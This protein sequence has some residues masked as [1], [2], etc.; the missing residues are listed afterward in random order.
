MKQTD[1]SAFFVK[2]TW[3]L[4]YCNYKIDGFDFGDEKLFI[5]EMHQQSEYKGDQF[6]ITLAKTMSKF[7]PRI[8]AES[9]VEM[10]YFKEIFLNILNYCKLMIPEIIEIDLNCDYFVD[11]LHSRYRKEGVAELVRQFV[12]NGKPQFT[13][14]PII[15]R[16]ITAFLSSESPI[17]YNALSFRMFSRRKK[18]FDSQTFYKE[19]YEHYFDSQTFYKE[20][21]EHCINSLI[22]NERRRT[23]IE[24]KRKTEIELIRDHLEYEQR[25]LSEPQIFYTEI[26]DEYEIPII[27]TIKEV[28]SDYPGWVK[29]THLNEDVKNPLIFN[30]EIL[31][32]FYREFDGYFCKTTEPAIFK[33]W[34]RVEP[35]G[36]PDIEKDILPYFCYAVWGINDYR[37]KTRCPIIQTWFSALTGKKTLFSK[38]KGK[39]ERRTI[40]SDMQTDIDNRIKIITRPVNG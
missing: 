22:K 32:K 11:M 19:Y 26:L 28:A 4:Y 6:Y 37:D 5:E 8:P 36:Q 3:H 16:G 10:P 33:N 21:Y 38:F 20:Y 1:I 40:K 7:I 25:I 18:S 13:P 15:A 24:K 34:F 12:K 39:V 9:R 23:P 14:A 17:K 35:V 27:E 2:L 30:E 29:E 31:N